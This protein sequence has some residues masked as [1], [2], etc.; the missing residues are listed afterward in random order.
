MTIKRAIK[1]NTLLAVYLTK[2]DSLCQGPQPVCAVQ[3]DTVHTHGLLVLLAV[4]KQ[5][6]HVQVTV[7]LVISFLGLPKMW[8][9]LEGLA[10]L[11]EV[12][13]EGLLAFRERLPA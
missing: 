8:V 11:A 3:R 1:N 6:L 2:R 13:V 9:F 7:V 4:E 5:R 10:D 12:T